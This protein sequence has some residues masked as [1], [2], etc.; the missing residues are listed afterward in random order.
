M[1]KIYN[2]QA[3]IATKIKLFLLRIFPDIRKTQLN[4]IPFIVIGM[5]LSES[6]VSSDIAK[7]LKDDFSLVQ[8]DS[9]SRRIRR[10]FSN[11]LFNP[12]LFYQSIIKFVI[13]NYKKKHNDKR[14]HIIFDHMYSKENYTILMFSLRVGKQG[15][16]IYFRCFEGIHNPDAFFDSTIIEGIDSV[17]SYFQN[18]DYKLIFLADR[19]FNSSK[20]LSHINSLGHSFCIRLKNNIKVNAFN[21]RENHYIHQYTVNLK[22]RKY[23]GKYYK[24]VYLFD[25]FPL[26]LNIVVSK[27]DATSSPWIIATNDEPNRAIRDYSYRFG[28]IESVF[29][30]Q[31]SNG[32]Y[33]ESI[34]NSSLNSFTSMYSILC[35]SVLFL[36]ILGTEFSK[37]TQCYKNVKL[38]THKIY[39]NGIKK[40]VMSLFNTGLTLFHLAFNSPKYIRIPVRFIL[41]DI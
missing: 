21:K 25:G 13:D 6:V 41:Y 30:N 20:I 39:S 22:G 16:P 5:L 4:I 37:N 15:I 8:L 38:T 32:F 19:W 31:K 2:T 18:S 10:F 17:S 34:S 12:Y 9:V 14:V 29:K 26:K 36:T 24:D 40:R 28:G 11:K 3:E 7:N 23:L 27:V 1:N 33:L 35:F